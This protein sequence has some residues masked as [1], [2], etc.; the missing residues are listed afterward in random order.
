VTETRTAYFELPQYSAGT[1]GTLTRLDA[2]EAF[3]K[4]EARAAYDDGTQGAALPSAN[5]KPGRYAKQTVSDGYQ[6][7]RRTDAGAWDFVGG[8]V[9]PTRIRYRGAA[10]GDIV[11]SSDVGGTQFGATLTA[12][13][14]LATPSPIRS[15]S[16]IAAGADVTA[17]LTTPGTTGRSYV[18]TRAAGDRGLVVEAHN[19]NAGPLLSLREAGGTF[20]TTFDSSGRLRSTV[21]AG[22]GAA[23]LVDNVPLRI[24]PDADD[25]TAL[26][27][28]G[29]TAGG[30]AP[31]LRAFPVV[32]D[33]DPILS[34]G[35]AVIALG[36]TGWA[37][38]SI[39]LA[40]PTIGLT[41][42][43]TVTGAAT[44]TDDLS[45]TDDLNVGDQ[46]TAEGGKVSTYDS[47]SNFGITSQIVAN[48]GAILIR[49]L[50]HSLVWRKRILNINKTIS[51]STAVDIQ[52]FDF[53]PRTTCYAELNLVTQ[54][55]VLSPGSA[56]TDSEP[57]TI[58]FR[59]RILADDGTTVLFT[60]DEIYELTLDAYDPHN[61]VGRGQV[62]VSD[63]PPLV[64]NAGTNYKIQLY[65]RRDPDTSISLV[66]KHLVGTIREGVLL[67]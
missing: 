56:A 22:L 49:D 29:R 44:I 63:C 61:Y 16:V 31:A 12:L 21:P 36:R 9:V 5:L 42:A 38:G 67:G 66:L 30:V 8:T 4:I 19:A 52:T 6:I 59:I 37:G 25:L 15:S 11:L 10:A 27:L 20:P 28:Y 57:N 34:V 1:D 64:L 45:I 58:I 48:G 32:G 18:R 53:S 50:R 55:A 35:P 47:G 46:I 60:G 17:D 54:W 23:S 65:G 7:H 62:I 33:T 51:P 26:D 2:N 39:G 41:G 40:A 43:V 14:E 3:G 24:S 13:G